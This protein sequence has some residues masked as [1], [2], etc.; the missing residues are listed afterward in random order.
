V[1]RIREE[2]GEVRA[3]DLKPKHLTEYQIA[4]RHAEAAG[5]TINRE[6]GSTPARRP[7]L[8]RG[9]EAAEPGLRRCRERSARALH[10]AEVAK[11]LNTCLRTSALC[12]SPS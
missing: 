9:P 11:S 4:R 5:G 7:T 3:V 10:A 8:P 12:G 6:A 2:L 1:K